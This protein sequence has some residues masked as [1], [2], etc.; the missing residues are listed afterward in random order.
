MEGDDPKILGSRGLKVAHL[1]VASILGSHKFE[2][3]RKQIEGSH[4][5][6]FCA[7]ETWLT[8]GKPTDLIS[9]HGYNV[10][11]LDRGWKTNNLDVNVKRGGGLICYVSQNINMNEFRYARFNQSNKD[12]EMQWISLDMTNMRR[13][14][15]INVYRPPQ[16]NYKVACKLIH[17]AI[18]DSNLKD[19]VDIFLLGDFNINLREK[20]E[21]ATKELN[22]TIDTW[23]LKQLIHDNTRFGMVNGVLRGSCIDNIFSNSQHIEES[24]VLDWNFSDHLMVVTRRKRATLSQEKV[25]FNG[26]SYKNYIKEDLQG[27]LINDNWDEYYTLADITLC[28]DLILTRVRRY[29]N[30]TCPLKVFKVK[31]IREPWVTNELIE[32]IKDKDRARRE[33]K[34]SGSREDWV[35]ARSERNRVGRLV[36][37]A[38]ADFLKDQQEQ[39]VD[40]PKKFWRLIK[41]IVPNKRKRSG[42]IS[43]NE[44]VGPGDERSIEGDQVADFIN[45]FFC[46]IGP[47]LAANHDEP[48]QFY[49]R[50]N[51]FTCPPMAT[52]FA[53]VLKLCKEIKTTKSSGFSDVS[54]KVFKDAFLVLV[55]QLVYLFN[56]SFATDIF[57][58]SWK[59]AT[60][61]P[62][63]KGGNK[64]DVST[65]RPV[66]LLPLPGKILEKIAHSRLTTFLENHKT[67]SNKQGGF[68]KGFSTTSSIAELT[69]I[70]F[71]NVNRGLT[72]I[73][74]FVD[75]R[76]AFD[77]VDHS[78]LLRKINCYGVRD[79]NLKWCANYL[80]NRTQ[81]TLAN[82]KLSDAK[83][84]TCGVPQGSVL[85]PLFFILY[86]NDVQEAVSVS[87]LQ[88][89]ADDTVIHSEGRSPDE[90]V[91][92]LQPSLTQ[93]SLWCKANKLSLNATKTKLMTFGTRHKV[94]KAKNVII[95]I[96]EVPLQIVPTYK[97]L[98]ITLDSTLSFNYHVKS[99]STAI[100]YK[101]NLLARIRKYLNEEVAMRIYKSMIL[102][103]FDYGDVIYNT[104]GQEGLDKLQRLQNR[105]LKICKGFN[106][107]FCT[108]EL[109][110]IT[111]MPKLSQ[112]RMAHVNNFM[113]SRLGNESLVDKRDIRTR[114]HDAPLFKIEIPTVEAYKRSIQYAGALQWNSLNKEIRGIDNFQN[115][116]AKQKST[117]NMT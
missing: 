13:I 102:P 24:V 106:V 80:T 3:M 87:K 58:D 63:Y 74:A 25:E 36:E 29:L 101:V 21:P 47:K 110:E 18:R 104:A 40:D 49:G 117:M 31:E 22:S 15:I 93:F 37:Q 62:L 95:R 79:S 67:I 56:Q 48:W 42:K 11:R 84:I 107:R 17:E 108:K 116:K 32:E 81:K 9:V 43:L 52:D 70:L 4:L 28:W 97:Y 96:G 27:E 60:I 83:G 112:R 113:Y 10:A 50:V 39:L 115:F 12:L 71:S 114:A 68:R 85:G 57:P 98:G 105:C 23:G 38:K 33:A 30:R 103:Y 86:V 75:L 41:D 44:R 14:V 6:V 92:K 109:H 77:T 8:S 65:Y 20:K 46:E 7:S 91:G 1:N 64:T 53:Q 55:P 26:R 34:R 51:E 61:I 73:A 16:G 2:M 54:S 99:A 19:N 5:N 82:G 90:A 78:I 111:K 76:K 89:Y 59:Q 45:N 69:D 94:K 88:L 72:S 66:S 35:H 100:S